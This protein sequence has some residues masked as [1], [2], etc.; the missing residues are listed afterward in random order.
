MTTL[1]AHESLQTSR[2]PESAHPRS[3]EEGP[4]QIC[5]PSDV[6]R[7]A[8]RRHRWRVSATLGAV[9]IAAAGIGSGVWLA[10]S[11][12][13]K[14]PTTEPPTNGSAASYPS[15]VQV[16]AATASA[17][18]ARYDA[19]SAATGPDPGHP[20]RI[21]TLGSVRTVGSVAFATGD[22]AAFITQIGLQNSGNGPDTP[23]LSTTSTAKMTLNGDQY[24]LIG[25]DRW[26]VLSTP[27]LVQRGVIG[28][29]GWANFGLLAAPTKDVRLVRV[30]SRSFDRI[31]VTAYRV[32]ASGLT[33]RCWPAANH[34]VTEV[35]LDA[36]KR[37]REVRTTMSPVFSRGQTATARQASTIDLRVTD[38]GASVV[39]VP[40]PDADPGNAAPLGPTCTWEHIRG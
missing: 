37:I 40:P 27:G 3:C 12:S 39:V 8:K 30:G 11:E 7:Q 15:V 25:E 35:W 18:T 23:R 22:G 14:P 34:V 19:V 29:I 31:P 32:E 36:Q 20:G 1:N 6:I 2:D 33:N 21:R 24:M 13:P 38:Y 9:V 28:S 17:G 4:S 5:E 10:G 16:L 26:G